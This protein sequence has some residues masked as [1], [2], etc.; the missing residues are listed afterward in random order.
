[1]K[2]TSENCMFQKQML[3]LK[4]VNVKLQNEVDELEQYGWRSCIRIDDIPQLSNESSSDVFNSI[5]DMFKSWFSSI[6]T[7]LTV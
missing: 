3:E 2:W 4:Q 6:L 5:V 7:E 1:M